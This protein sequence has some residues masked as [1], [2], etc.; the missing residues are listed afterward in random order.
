MKSRHMPPMH[1]ATYRLFW[2]S[3]PWLAALLSLC[4]A[5]AAFAQQE[6]DPPGRVAHLSERQ[7]GVVFAPH[8][9]EEWMEL[10]QNRPLTAGDRLWSDRGA[11]AELHIGSATLHVA[12]ES[13]LGVS[14]L[15][16]RTAQF[17]L[18]QGSLNA[19]VRELAPGENFEVGTP[20]L[21]V[22]A[23]QPGDY[24]IDV[25]GDG[26]STRVTVHSGLA[27][28]FGENGES[29]QLGA[30]QQASFAGR[31]LAQVQRP[32]SQQDE[33]GAWAAARNHMEDQSIAARH[34]PR[35][36][37]G[38]AQLD[39]HGTWGQDP[40][41]GAVWYPRVAVQDW[42]PY[43]YGH[44]SWIQPWGWTW[45][46]DA[47]WGFAPFHYG[48]WTMVHNRWAWVPGRLAA[49]PVYSP[50]L[51]VFLGGGDRFSLG[52]GSGPAVGWY[53]LAPGE[54]WYPAY[55]TTPRYVNFAN[56]NINL[57]AYPRHYNNHVWRQRPH[58]VTAVR[59]DDFRRS[60]PVHRH[61][62]ALQ[63]HMLGN[64]QIGA[65]PVRVE[66][67]RD[68]EVRVMP[69]LHAA[70]PAAVQ[71]MQ[72]GRNWGDRDRGDRDRVHRE[73]APAVREQYRAEREQDRLQRDAE[74]AA[75][76]QQRQAEDQRR[77]GM[78]RW[79]QEQ[80]FRQQQ[81]S[82]R[83]QQEQV[84]RHQEQVQRHEQE[85]VQREGFRREHR[86][87]RIRSLDQVR[88]PWQQVPPAQINQP[89]RQHA[90]PLHRGSDRQEDR[91]RGE[92][93][94][95]RGGGGDDGRGRGPWQRN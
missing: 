66:G 31:S 51:V 56:F 5:G 55:R 11:R 60:R 57:N 8:G 44:W 63:P 71:G 35:G 12:G 68:R 27:S 25:E 73:A 77:R 28:V 45:I 22:R 61:W 88:S 49:R 32:V 53:P 62:Q 33:F 37:V 38:Y 59:E 9:E 80:V 75:R 95:H 39:Q 26:R 6:A 84:R 82:V 93:R 3:L 58:A 47:P 64:A 42:A 7:G 54:A 34:V 14:E 18:Q 4:L 10:P 30:G 16:D 17:L 1:S 89:Q 87:E 20:N 70:P 65:A 91:G 24:R 36:V 67:R 85:R 90:F 15:D 52:V 72:P 76:E 83:Q 78:Q 13:H 2:R 48:R 43:R 40:N 86:E 69:R 92:G 81:E 94:G 74:R 50:A 19:R 79:Q 21:A 29:I 41:L 46:D 23:L